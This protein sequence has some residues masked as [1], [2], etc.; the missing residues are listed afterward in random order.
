MAKRKG[1]MPARLA[2]RGSAPAPNSRSIAAQ[3]PNIAA[4]CKALPQSD[5][6]WAWLWGAWLVVLASSSD[7]KFPK[8]MIYALFISLQHQKSKCLDRIIHRPN[9][10]AKESEA[11]KRLAMLDSLLKEEAGGAVCLVRNRCGVD[12]AHC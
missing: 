2:S 1:V 7:M 9:I 6:L 3:S 12:L 5:A 8:L 10:V 11:P 4:L